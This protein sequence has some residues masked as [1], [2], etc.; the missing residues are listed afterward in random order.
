MK[1]RMK[2][3]RMRISTRDE[4]EDGEEEETEAER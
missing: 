1:L 2:M 4:V 3:R